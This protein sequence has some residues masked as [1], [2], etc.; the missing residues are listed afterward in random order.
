MYKIKHIPTCIFLDYIFTT[1]LFRTCY[2]IILVVKLF[3]QKEQGNVKTSD[4]EPELSQG[5]ADHAELCA[6]TDANHTSTPFSQFF[7]AD[8]LC[9]DANKRISFCF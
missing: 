9:F 6:N 4:V 8:I 2:I 1:K 7:L 5:S 3:R